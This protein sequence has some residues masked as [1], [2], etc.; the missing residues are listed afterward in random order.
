MQSP[1][2]LTPG[3]QFLTSRADLASHL[4]RLHC[5]AWGFVD[6][7]R[8]V[9]V[10]SRRLHQREQRTPGNLDPDEWAILPRV[11][12]LIQANAKSPEVGPVLELLGNALRADHA[13]MV[14]AD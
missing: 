11:I 14:E 10:S 12:D 7:W 4:V 6:R 5:S 8:F 9:F 1:P 3:L 13:K 2:T